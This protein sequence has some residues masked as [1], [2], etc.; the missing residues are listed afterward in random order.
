MATFD[1]CPCYF[2]VVYKSDKARCSN[3]SITPAWHVCIYICMYVSVSSKVT[4]KLASSS[5]HRLFSKRR[6]V[7]VHYHADACCYMLQHIRVST[8][9]R[10]TIKSTSSLPNLSIIR[11]TRELPLIHASK[12]RLSNV[13]ETKKARYDHK[14]CNFF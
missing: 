11:S 13:F 14:R 2:P 6:Y 1:Y 3:V 9:Q 12:I 5:L 7:V 10:N 8:T 4:S